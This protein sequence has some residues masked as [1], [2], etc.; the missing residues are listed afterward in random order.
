MKQTDI[1]RRERELKRAQKKEERT[2]RGECGDC[3]TV[4]EYINLLNALFFHDENKIYNIQT[5]DKILEL[6]EELKS[7]HPEKQWD[8]VL[9]KAVKKTGVK[10]KEDAVKQ[11]KELME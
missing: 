11:M 8:N 3:P 5:E 1:L 9:R 7:D 10:D 4:G 2:A 6:L